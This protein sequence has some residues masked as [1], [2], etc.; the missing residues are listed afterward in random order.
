MNQYSE[1]YS[2]FDVNLKMNRMTGDVIKKKNNDDIRQS[3]GLLLRT[4]FYDRKWHPEIGSYLPTLLFNQDD[5]FIKTVLKEQIT[6][7]VENYEP[8]VT[9]ESIEI[10]HENIQDSFNGK[11][12]IRIHYTINII[13]V[14]DTFVFSVNRLR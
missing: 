7:L 1:V 14:K 12:T 2:D 8:R 5:E 4:R 6:T 11:I 3:L 10:G 9:I 13:N